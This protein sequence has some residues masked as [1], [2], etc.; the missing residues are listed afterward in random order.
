MTTAATVIELGQRIRDLLHPTDHDHTRLIRTFKCPRCRAEPGEACD[1]KRTRGH[2]NAF[3][4]HHARRQDLMIRLSYT[5]REQ[6]DI[7]WDLETDGIRPERVLAEITKTRAY[8][9]LVATGLLK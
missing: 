5:V 7:V 9:H 6:V 2:Y 3:P 8:R 4:T 1:M